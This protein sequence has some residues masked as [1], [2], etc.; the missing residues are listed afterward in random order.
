MMA[1]T[2]VT[3][4]TVRAAIEKADDAQSHIGEMASIMQSVNLEI[5]PEECL[6][7]IRTLICISCDASQLA[8][9]IN[10]IRDLAEQRIKIR[11]LQQASGAK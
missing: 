10:G 3:I 6:E 11:N 4:E 5:E 9:R 2:K 8:M 1:R 7:M